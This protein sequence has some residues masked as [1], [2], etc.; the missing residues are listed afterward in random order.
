MTK[1]TQGSSVNFNH[2]IALCRIANEYPTTL[3]SLMEAVQNELDANAN[4]IHILLNRK[5]RNMIVRGNGDGVNKANFELALT[6]VCESVKERGKLGQFGIGLISPLGKCDYFTFTSCPKHDKEKQGYIEWHFKTESIRKQDKDVTVPSRFREDLIHKSLAPDGTRRGLTAVDWRTEV[7]IYKYDKDKLISRIPSAQALFDGIVERYGATMRRNNVRVSIAIINEDGSEDL[8]TGKAKQFSGKKL[9]EVVVNHPDSGA[10]T[11]RLY[12]ARKTDKGYAGVV[13]VGEADNDFRIRFNMFARST[14]LLDGVLVEAL[15]SGIFEGEI[16]SSKAKLNPNRKSFAED[17]ALLGFCESIET[18]YKEHGRKHFA[19]AQ[20]EREDQRYQQLGRE[21]MIALEAML[22]L[23][24]YADLMDVIN[25]FKRGTIGN[26]HHNPEKD[27]VLGK[28]KQKSV[29]VSTANGHSNGG[30]NGGGEKER[31][32]A[33]ER[34]SHHP[35]TVAGPQG[36]RRTM[37]K[38]DSLGLQFSH[39]AME[40]SDRLWVLDM[41]VGVLHFNIRHPVWVAHEKSNRQV[42]Q[43][44]EFIAIQAL[45]LEKMPEDWRKITDIFVGEILSPF[46]FLIQHSRSFT[47]GRPTGEAAE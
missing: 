10:T 44:Q 4:E 38:S 17:Q 32:P 35:F 2:G 1:H 36:K 9:P 26:G 22:Q 47:F 43:L 11:V 15:T 19:D 24:K 14:K 20:E 6:Q 21:S 3:E 42:K 27:T 46:S 37:V 18:W 28:Q 34:E 31:N 30:G 16:L 45:H 29:A 12:L 7:A 23:P 40:G 41:Q 13:G 25:S 39:T 5:A 8:A 33:E